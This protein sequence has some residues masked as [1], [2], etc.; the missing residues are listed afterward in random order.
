EPVTT[1]PLRAA[2]ADEPARLLATDCAAVFGLAAVLASW[3]C[4]LLLAALSVAALAALGRYRRKLILSVVDDTVRGVAGTGMAWAAT[5]WVGETVSASRELPAGW[6]WWLVV[7]G[8]VVLARAGTYAALRRGR[9]RRPKDAVLVGCSP[10][11]TQ[12]AGR[13][14]QR[15]ELG[16]R[17]I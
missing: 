12:L 13:L 4:G 5:G 10:V 14:S 17:P 6:L 8:C 2:L 11:L 3:R 1:R 15:P 16:L 9:V 7:A